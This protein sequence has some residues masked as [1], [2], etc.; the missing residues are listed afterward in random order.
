MRTTASLEH[1]ANLLQPGVEFGPWGLCY[2]VL[3]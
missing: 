1:V 3:L 2:T